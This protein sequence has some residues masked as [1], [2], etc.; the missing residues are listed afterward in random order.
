[1]RGTPT[2]VGENDDQEAGG[3]WK[4]FYVAAQSKLSLKNCSI[5]NFDVGLRV[6]ATGKVLLTA[7][8]VTA[9]NIGIL[10]SFVR[11]K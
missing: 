4:G 8:D 2:D 7:C 6:R 3:S 11:M 5:T 9:C 10:V 1:M